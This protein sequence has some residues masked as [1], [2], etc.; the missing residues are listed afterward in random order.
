MYSMKRQRDDVFE[1]GHSAIKI[2]N[3][4]PSE[5]GTMHFDN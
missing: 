1:L 2:S 3:C 5:V 4:K